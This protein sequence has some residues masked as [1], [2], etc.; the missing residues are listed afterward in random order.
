MPINQGDQNYPQAP[1]RVVV[2]PKRYLFDNQSSDA[3]EGVS[4][5]WGAGGD[6]A[7]LNIKTFSPVGESIV[8]ATINFASTRDTDIPIVA[9]VWQPF[10]FNNHKLLDVGDHLVGQASPGKVQ[11]RATVKFTKIVFK[12]GKS[13]SINAIGTDM[14]GNVG[15]PGV[16]VGDAVLSAMGPVLLSTASAVIKSFEQSATQVTTSGGI[17]AVA[18]SLTGGL[19]GAVV[20]AGAGA[21]GAT[22]STTQNA[23]QSGKN[24]GISGAGAAMDKISQLLA[25]DMAENKPYLLVKAGTPCKALLMNPMDVS[26]ASYGQ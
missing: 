10:Y 3:T 4:A 21:L 2:D 22:Q 5:S 17:P 9:A 12:T 23:L 19:T 6:G 20:N 1:A 14:E 15:L 18:N 16:Q 8:A 7:D 25:D 11:G 26:K 13:L 24:A